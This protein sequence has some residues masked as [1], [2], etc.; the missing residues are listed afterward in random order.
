MQALDI[1]VSL[2]AD[3][4]INIDAFEYQLKLNMDDIDMKMLELKHF[5]GAQVNDFCFQHRFL[6]L[7]EIISQQFNLSNSNAE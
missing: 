7:I 4:S 5:S 6:V 1:D 3:F 2:N